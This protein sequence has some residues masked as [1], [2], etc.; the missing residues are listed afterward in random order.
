MELLII[1]G[2]I[3][4]IPSFI[5]G[6]SNK[7]PNP[8]GCVILNTFLGWTLLGWVVSLAWAFARIPD[9][10]KGGRRHGR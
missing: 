3:Y 1:L 10:Q 9:Y 5:A 2:L 8:I 7:H 4:F 6:S